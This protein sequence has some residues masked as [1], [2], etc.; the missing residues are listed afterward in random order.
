M[1]SD[2]LPEKLKGIILHLFGEEDKKPWSDKS[3]FYNEWNSTLQKAN[4]ID[5]KKTITN[6]KKWSLINIY[7]YSFYLFWKKYSF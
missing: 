2:S 5:L 6:I 4:F 7:S 3:P 1:W